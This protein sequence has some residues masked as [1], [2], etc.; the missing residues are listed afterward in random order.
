[1]CQSSVVVVA[2]VAVAIVV[3]SGVPA[4]VVSIARLPY[5]VF[6]FSPIVN[7]L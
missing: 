3:V 2:A 5:Q 4:I 6:D 7:H 1:M